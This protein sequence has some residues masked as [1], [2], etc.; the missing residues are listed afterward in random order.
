[1]SAIPED[2]I[3][4][5]Q[6]LSTEVTRPFPNSTKIY[7]NGPRD[8]IRVGMRE[9]KCADTPTNNGVEKNPPITVYDTS[10]PYTDP[11]V[12]VDLLKGIPDLRSRWIEERGDTELLQ[13]PSSEFGQ[14]RQN[15]EKL[16]HLRFEHI[17]APRRAP[18]STRNADRGYP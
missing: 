12:T 11:E 1:M 9:I 6:T 7:V 4:K 15:D 2:F 10:G 13:G 18:R 16:A 3:A 17:R 8:D 14:N 5:T